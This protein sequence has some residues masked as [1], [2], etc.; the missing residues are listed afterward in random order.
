MNNKGLKEL[1]ILLA[2]ESKD[3]NSYTT[4]N[5]NTIT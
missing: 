2:K 5:I 3:I 4:N 1:K